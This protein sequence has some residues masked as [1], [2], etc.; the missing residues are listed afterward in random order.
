VETELPCNNGFVSHEQQHLMNMQ[1]R[2]ETDY[3]I[4]LAAEQVQA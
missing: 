2:S 4:D 3:A 1:M